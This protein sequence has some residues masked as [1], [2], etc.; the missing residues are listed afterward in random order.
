MTKVH[1]IGT[2]DTLE[3]TLRTL[4]RLGVLQIED[5]T[6]PGRGLGLPKITLDAVTLTQR[7]QIG[8]LVTRL[9]SL[10][11]LLPAPALPLHLD[12]SYAEASSKPTAALVSEAKGL[13]DDLA[14]IMQ[15]LAVQR[16]ELE[17][18]RASLP[19]YAATIRQVMPL[20][21]ELPELEDYETV[22]LLN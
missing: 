10:L 13:L 6:E 9:E 8:R 12:Q 5:V 1:I 4:H 16:D 11:A 7:E 15:D 17:A 21:A 19:R 3:P 20:A 2:K 14:P 18:E 22:A